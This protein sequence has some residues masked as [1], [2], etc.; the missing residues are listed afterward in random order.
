MD[1]W[2]C[3]CINNTV[4]REVMI[5]VRVSATATMSRKEGGP[6]VVSISTVSVSSGCGFSLTQWQRREPLASCPATYSYKPQA[7]LG[8]WPTRCRKQLSMS[9]SQCRQHDNVTEVEHLYWS[10]YTRKGGR[11]HLTLI[12]RQQ[13]RLQLCGHKG[14]KFLL[15]AGTITLQGTKRSTITVGALKGTL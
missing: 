10:A 6:P 8:L 14:G 4:D 9:V 1:G 12:R 13:S 5:V 2:K 3:K 7:G 11:E 15:Y